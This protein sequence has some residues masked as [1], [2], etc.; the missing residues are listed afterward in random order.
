MI[1]SVVLIVS[2]SFYSVEHP[3]RFRILLM[4][5]RFA[6]FTLAFDLA[7]CSFPSLETF[8]AGQI[9]FSLLDPLVYDTP[10]S[11]LPQELL[12]LTDLFLHFAGYL[13]GFAFGLQLGIVG[14]FPGDLL[15]LTLCFVKRSF[16]LVPHARFHGIPP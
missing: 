16:R 10:L 15:G 1:S 9:A 2:S 6:F 3:G 12:G 14:D 11:L 5:A 13:F 8:V 4:T 7:L